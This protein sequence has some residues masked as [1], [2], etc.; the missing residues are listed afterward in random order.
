[1]LRICLVN[2]QHFLL[3]SFLPLALF[4]VANSGAKTGRRRGKKAGIAGKDGDEGECSG[5]KGLAC[6]AKI[7]LFSH[8]KVGFWIR[9]KPCGART[10][11]ARSAN[12]VDFDP[13]GFLQLLPGLIGRD[14]CSAFDAGESQAG[15]ISQ[16]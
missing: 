9:G 2:I 7:P 15:S 16:G 13:L 4:E 5:G 12:H 10:G 14:G 3:I 11:H 1:M 6:R 8:E